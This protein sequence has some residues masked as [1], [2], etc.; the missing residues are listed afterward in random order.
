MLQDIRAGRGTEI[1][2]MNGAVVREALA[3]SVSVPVNGMLTDLV[4]A[5]QMLAAAKPVGH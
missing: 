2:Y 1:E 3:L 4:R 5:R